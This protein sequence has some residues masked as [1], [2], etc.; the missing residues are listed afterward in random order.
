MKK[1]APQALSSRKSD[2]DKRRLK[3]T[4]DQATLA[5]LLRTATYQGISR[6]KGNPRQFGLPPHNRP[7]GDET[8]CDV[9]ANFQPG[10]MATLPVLL[11]RGLR[12]GLVGEVETQGIPTIIWTVADNGWIFEAR[13]TNVGRAEYHGYPVRASEAIARIVYDRFANWARMHGGP[14]EIAAADTC[15]ALYGFGQ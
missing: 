12:A 5:R 7:R 9:H 1:P 15:R 4:P 2:N 13:I 6:H 8:L 10:D 3:K 11:R 14:Q